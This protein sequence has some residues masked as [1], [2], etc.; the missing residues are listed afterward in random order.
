MPPSVE[1]LN[2]DKGRCS[3]DR[4]R[5]R[6]LRVMSPTSYQTAP[7]AS[8]EGGPTQVGTTQRVSFRALLLC[9]EESAT[10]CVVL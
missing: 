2:Y 6:D 7:P 4:I 8:Q 1:V 9:G 10:L 5:I 3:S